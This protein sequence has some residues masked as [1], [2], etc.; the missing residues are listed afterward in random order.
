MKPEWKEQYTK[1]ND[2]YAQEAYAYGETPNLYFKSVINSYTPGKLLLPAEGEGRNAVYA[3]GQGWEVEAFDLSA[4]GKKKAE[5]LAQKNQVQIHYQSG[6][7]SEISYPEESF[8]MIGL[9]Y[10]HFPAAV[11][12]TYHQQLIRYLKKGGMVVFEAFSKSHLEWQRKNEAVGGPKNLDDLFSTEEIARDFSGF[13]IITL[14]EAEVAL[15][16][17]FGHIGTGA[18]IRFIGIKQ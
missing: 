10:A 17:G 12:S 3:A 1:W 13:D 14:E 6:E 11:K 7:F 2:R 8:D 16:E 4:E 15:E 5:A 18:V 9:I